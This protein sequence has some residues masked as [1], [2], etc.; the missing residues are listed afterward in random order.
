[1][2]SNINNF[3]S[4]KGVWIWIIKPNK[5]PVKP[6]PRPKG[7]TLGEVL[8]KFEIFSFVNFFSIIL[9]NIRHKV[10]TSSPNSFCT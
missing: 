10:T 2:L 9:L 8:N 7:H 6:T 1:M 4:V 5:I 3:N